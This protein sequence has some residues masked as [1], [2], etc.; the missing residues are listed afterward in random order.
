MSTTGS[1]MP[2]AGMRRQHDTSVNGGSAPAVERPVAHQRLLD[3]LSSPVTETVA[4]LKPCV[5]AAEAMARLGAAVHRSPLQV[6]LMQAGQR[7]DVAAS[8]LLDGDTVD[9]ERALSEDAGQSNKALS[10][11]L[12]A[13]EFAVQAVA[14]HRVEPTVL[15]TLAD[16]ITGRDNPVRSRQLGDRERRGLADGQ[17]FVNSTEAL[18]QGLEYW[19]R[20]VETGGDA[21][22]LLLVGQA[23]RCWMSLRPYSRNNVSIGLA[24]TDALLRAECA[25]DACV[26]PLAWRFARLEAD[27]RQALV[28]EESAWL[29]WWLGAV[30]SMAEH[31]LTTL[32]AWEG[33]LDSVVEC[34]TRAGTGASAQAARV[35]CRPGF[36]LAELIELPGVSRAR[37]QQY[38]DAQL[39]TGAFT[40]SDH[41]KTK[42]FSH[43]R[44]LR[45]LASPSL[46]TS[47]AIQK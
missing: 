4:V 33:E 5:S 25:P 24:M 45:L 7:L 39:E 15:Q 9:I 36:S 46:H 12:G 10:R 18:G 29:I 1:P 11:G 8:L 32:E 26:P 41:G 27:Y 23:H 40:I 14:Q 47:I 31:W 16:R 20:F 6:E 44:V 43:P 34:Q 3:A 2:V 17:R 22:H 30:R 37:A 21:H 28:K 38:I 13:R 19:S 35:M 42:R